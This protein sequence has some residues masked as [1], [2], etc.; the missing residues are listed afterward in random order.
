MLNVSHTRV[1][2]DSPEALSSLKRLRALKVL[3][4]NGCKGVDDEVVA[5][6]HAALPYLRAV[7]ML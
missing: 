4:V 2:V 6:L 7:K 5:E 1:E 3:A